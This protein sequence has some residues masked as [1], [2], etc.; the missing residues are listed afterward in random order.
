[1]DRSC[2]KLFRESGGQTPGVGGGIVCDGFDL[3]VF[4]LLSLTLPHS[5]KPEVKGKQI[6]S[7][8]GILSSKGLMKY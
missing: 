5:M 4:F 7:T 8:D 3:N 2:K 6:L 1:M